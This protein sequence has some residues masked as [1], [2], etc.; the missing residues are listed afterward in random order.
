MDETLSLY[1]LA[2]TES[3]LGGYRIGGVV[4]PSMLFLKDQAMPSTIAA[5]ELLAR[6][7][8]TLAEY[9]GMRLPHPIILPTSS[10]TATRLI[11]G[12][13]HETYS[14]RH[15]KDDITALSMACAMLVVDV[16]H[17]ASSQQVQLDQDEHD[18]GRMLVAL[19]KS[20]VLGQLSDAAARG[21]VREQDRPKLLSVRKLAARIVDEYRVNEQWETINV[22]SLSNSGETDKTGAASSVIGDSFLGASSIQ[23]PI[24]SR[25]A[26]AHTHAQAPPHAQGQRV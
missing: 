1:R 5:L 18:I 13:R 22:A 9:L 26:Q 21:A 17:L 15:S 6:L 14:L 4:V 16:H 23:L 20:E 12:T 7:V 25:Q 24:G 3:E 19:G 2:L 11:H 8:N 10:N